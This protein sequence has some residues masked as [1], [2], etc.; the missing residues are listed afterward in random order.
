MRPNPTAIFRRPTPEQAELLRRRVRLAALRAA[1]AA[2]EAELAH[3]RAQILS[4]KGRY[5][6]QVGVLYIQLDDWED[7]IA[8]LN[9]ATAT[10]AAASE[11]GAPEPAL[12]PSKGL[13]SETGVAAP[14]P[15]LDLKSLFREVA[16]RIHPD[17]ARNH[18]DAAH[19]TYLM[20]Q[21][22]DAYLR[23]DAAVLQRMLNGHDA[24]AE[25]DRIATQL[26]RTDAQIQ[27]TAADL[28]AIDAELETLAQ[29][30]MAQL[31]QR[32]ILAATKGQDLLADLAARV[33]GRISLAMRRYEFDAARLKRNQGPFDPPPLLSAETPNPPAKPDHR[34]VRIPRS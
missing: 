33:K 13:A 20:T 21:A 12:S 22:N 31:Q 1:L 18:L 4:F 29:S 6:R 2:R 10:P 15:T 14:A 26:A 8:Q 30:E 32:S 23:N 34:N 16:K 28:T 9:G 25:P 7:R 27:Q 11:A 5:I 19:R 17:F 24:A 3:F